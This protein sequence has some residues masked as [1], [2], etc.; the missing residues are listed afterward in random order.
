MAIY[1][2]ILISIAVFAALLALSPRTEASRIKLG[3]GF[4]S[5]IGLILILVLALRG[6]SVGTDVQTYLDYWSLA[7]TRDLTEASRFEPAFVLV[8]EVSRSLSGSPHFYL[9]VI[10]VL[11]IAPVSY[12]IR[13]GSSLPLLSWTMYICLGFYAFTFSGLRQAIALALT[14]V[15]IQLIRKQKLLPFLMTVGLAWTFHASALIF[16]PAFWVY[17]L[18]LTPISI[19]AY[20]AFVPVLYLFREPLFGWFTTQFFPAYEVTPSSS[21][22]W[23]LFSGAIVVIG[24]ILWCMASKV[25]MSDTS[26]SDFAGLL[27]IATVGMTLM[28]FASVGTNV[29]RMADYYYFAIVIALP[30][31]LN[32]V[33]SRIRHPVRVAIVTLL[34]AI[35]GFQMVESPYSIVPYTLFTG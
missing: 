10:A 34:I 29:M 30:G 26:K 1:V 4:S 23:L 14:A 11:S 17:R 3:A 6:T 25:A 9:A 21:Y 24:W 31:V 33:S 20:F 27:Q 7:D 22:T 32:L 12:A 16:L 19:A 28:L 13:K 8:T 15:A 35:Y 5:F 2:A 18:R